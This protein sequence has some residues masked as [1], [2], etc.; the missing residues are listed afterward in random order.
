MNERDALVVVDR[1][2]RQASAELRRAVDQAIGDERSSR[3]SATVGPVTDDAARV[4]R[5]ER[6][7]PPARRRRWVWAAAAA[8]VAVAGVVGLLIVGRGGDDETPPATTAD[9][10]FLVPG[11]LPSGWGPTSAVRGLEQS[12]LSGTATVYG[13]ATL[14]DSMGGEFVYVLR[15]NSVAPRDT[16]DRATVDVAGHDATIERD[17]ETWGVTVPVADHTFVVSG[18]GVTRAE[19]LDVAAAAVEGRP[20][21]PVLPRGLVE[22]A[23][24]WLDVTGQPGADGLALAYEADSGAGRIGIAQRPGRA[25]ELGLFLMV[26]PAPDTVSEVTVRGQ[27]GLQAKW[28]GG[29][30]FDFEG[31]SD[32]VQW[33]EP[34]GLLVT[35][36]GDD[37]SAEELDRF[38]EQM[39]ESTD[40]EIDEL[41]E[42]FPEPET[43]GDVEVETSAVAVP[44][45][46]VAEGDRGSDH[47]TVTA[48]E[49]A[50][51]QQVVDDVG[52][53]AGSFW[54]SY[55]D[56]YQ[57]FGFAPDSEP[58]TSPDLDVKAGP[59]PNDLDE[60]IVIGV[61]DASIAEVVV[62][63][64]GQPSL[65]VEIYQHDELTDQVIVGFLP[66]AY[67]NGDVVGLDSGG[68]EIARTP[69]RSPAAKP[70]S[71]G[72]VAQTLPP[73]PTEP[74]PTGSS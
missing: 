48:S 14:V 26:L 67:T 10:P 44:E 23:D 63:M 46:V 72:A 24:G 61:A 73:L 49:A 36:S 20:V 37:L 34:P 54:V 38:I 18:R 35:V 74:A 57:N 30:D 68:R 17:G 69:L 42:A 50:A 51:E 12:Q 43:S 5:L 70:E 28:Q 1:R 58:G 55:E 65:P 52:L 66:D 29:G 31:L 22:V 59:R 64:A 25:S 6:S 62:E 4:V 53:V 8:V 71:D 19:I 39:R 27:P 13:S 11:W 7:I 15:F 45:V 60:T 47:W 41:I 40:S 9:Q 33:I 32:V 56:E 3:E 2:M 21:E 16:A